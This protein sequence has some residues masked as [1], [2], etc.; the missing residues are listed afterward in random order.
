M[1]LLEASI[2][3]N[4]YL[5]EEYNKGTRPYASIEEA[6]YAPDHLLEQAGFFVVDIKKYNER[7]VKEIYDWCEENIGS[8][9]YTHIHGSRWV[10]EH[11]RDAI[12]FTLRWL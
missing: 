5:S 11:E 4:E 3:I 6:V 9:L 7:M 1:T 8:M 2:K 10:F 12:M